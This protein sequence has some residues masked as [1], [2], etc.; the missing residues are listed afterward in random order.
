ML[1]SC[2]FVDPRQDGFYLVKKP[3]NMVLLLAFY[4]FMATKGAKYLM[5]N[6]KPFEL[7]RILIVYNLVQ[8]ILSGW[9]AK[10]V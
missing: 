6:Q 5:K 9:F 8:V 7:K 4:W 1:N 10:T 2:F 3:V